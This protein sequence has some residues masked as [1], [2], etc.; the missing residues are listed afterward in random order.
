MGS[1]TSPKKKT[2]EQKPKTNESTIENGPW[3]KIIIPL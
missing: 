2:R 3:N 1:I